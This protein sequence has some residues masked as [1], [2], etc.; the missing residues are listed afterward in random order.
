MFFKY[1]YVRSWMEF[2]CRETCCLLNDGLA[3]DN[4]SRLRGISSQTGC[5]QWIRASDWSRRDKSAIMVNSRQ[6]PFNI[7]LVGEKWGGGLLLLPILG[8]FY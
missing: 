8:N 4:G 5:P 2:L 7:S 3:N 1:T 6:Y